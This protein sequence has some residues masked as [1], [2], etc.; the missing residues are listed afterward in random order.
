MGLF[1]KRKN[2]H[3]ERELRIINDKAPFNF[4]EAYKSLRTNID[5]LSSENNYHT[6]LITSAGPW[7]GKSTV[8]IN[9]AVAMADSGKRVC[10][11]DC[12]MRKGSIASYLKISR[13]SAGITNILD[14]KAELKT[15]ILYNEALKIH[16]LPVGPL[17]SNPSE[18]IGSPKM[19][20]LV[21][22]LSRRFDYVFIDTPPVSVVTDAAILSRY[23]D[24]VLLVVRADETTKQALNLSKKNLE[25][26]NARIL[27]VV[28]NDY[29]AKKHS[30]GNG[31]YYSYSYSY[32]YG[33]GQEKEVFRAGPD[34]SFENIFEKKPKEQNDQGLL[35]NDESETKTNDLKPEGNS[36]KAVNDTKNGSL[37]TDKSVEKSEAIENID[38]LDN[39]KMVNFEEK[40]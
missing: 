17:P 7:D 23:V 11:V 22:A 29:N 35:L 20:H 3:K 8:A 30:Y 12:D 39:D 40:K 18:V 6:I 15:T 21:Q 27:G 37:E 36:E 13:S 14:E 19:I 31:Y 28:L 2:E 5:F 10:L 26:V 32:K 16:I 25:D 34:E 38:Y 1:R 24:G 33:Y 9:L 4:V